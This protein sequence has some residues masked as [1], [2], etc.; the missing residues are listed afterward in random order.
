MAAYLVRRLAY[1]AVTVLG[2]L[3]LLF[4]LFFAVTDPDDIARKAV[5]ERARPE[6]YVQ[7]KKNHGY[8]KPLFLNRAHRRA[9]AQ[10]LHG[11]AAV[12]ALPAHAHLRLRPQRRRRHAD[13]Q[14]PAGR[15]RAQPQPHRAAVR[16]GAAARAWRSR[17]S[18]RSS[19]RPTSTAPCSWLCMLTMSVASLLYIIG[20]QYL[21]GMLLK[22]FPDLR[23]RS[24]TPR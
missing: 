7:W 12:R 11:H 17:C 15:R 1:G 13:R 20:G 21:I 2:V 23:L 6:V 14:A 9:D 22:W 5:G 24:R 4:V 3:F 16:S 18:W 19:A 8:D 10:P